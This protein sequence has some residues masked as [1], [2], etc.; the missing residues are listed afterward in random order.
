MKRKKAKKPSLADYTQIHVP[1]KVWSINAKTGKQL[2]ISLEEY[3]KREIV[4][5]SKEVH[6]LSARNA[7]LRELLGV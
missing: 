4:R 1:W 5:L 3:Q 7:K 6:E 2:Q